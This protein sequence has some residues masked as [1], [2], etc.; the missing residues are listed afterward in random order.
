MDGVHYTGLKEE[1]KMKE[2]KENEGLVSDS[3][4][5]VLTSEK[6]VK[7][8][9]RSMKEIIKEKLMQL[10]DLATLEIM[11][12]VH[13]RMKKRLESIKQMSSA[14]SIK[15][16]GHWKTTPPKMHI[17]NLEGKKINNTEVEITFGVFDVD[18]KGN[19]KEYKNYSEVEMPDG[20]IVKKHLSSQYRIKY[21]VTESIRTG[22][23]ITREVVTMDTEEL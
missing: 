12:D 8:T 19:K 6:N 7:T 14:D 16:R 13:V 21:E 3:I 2:K 5:E 20:K 18:E 9:V 23:P 11:L 22:K 17:A 15:V 1:N 4:P 10:S